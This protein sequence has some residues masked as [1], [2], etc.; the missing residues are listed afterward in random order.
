MTFFNYIYFLDFSL[1][2][3]FAEKQFQ[4]LLQ[5][6]EGEGNAQ[7]NRILYSFILNAFEYSMMG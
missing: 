6:C 3:D 7:G 1:P 2:S 4:P 5:L